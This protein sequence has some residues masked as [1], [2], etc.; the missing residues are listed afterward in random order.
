MR[1]FMNS[2]LEYLCAFNRFAIVILAAAGTDVIADKY[3]IPWQIIA[4]IVVG[5]VVYDYYLSKKRNKKPY[6]VE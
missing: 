3:N 1:R 6:N 5:L 2:V 4:F